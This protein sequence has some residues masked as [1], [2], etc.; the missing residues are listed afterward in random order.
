ML[1]DICRESF[2]PLLAQIFSLSRYLNAPRFFFHWSCSGFLTCI[3]SWHHLINPSCKARATA[4]FYFSGVKQ[5]REIIHT[6]ICRCSISNRKSQE[7]TF[8]SFSLGKSKGKCDPQ[9]SSPFESFSHLPVWNYSFNRFP[10]PLPELKS[11]KYM[12]V[13]SN[14][15]SHPK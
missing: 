10:S 2:F 9:P 5:R 13:F 3:S 8:F 6:A 7:N 4:H 1:L 14:C 15:I 12:N 11:C